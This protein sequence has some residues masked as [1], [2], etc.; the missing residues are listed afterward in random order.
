MLLEFQDGLVSNLDWIRFI[1]LKA[2]E[3]MLH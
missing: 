1:G 3:K 2:L